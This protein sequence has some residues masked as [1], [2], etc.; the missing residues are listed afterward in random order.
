MPI[1]HLNFKTHLHPYKR[2]LLCLLLLKTVLLTLFILYG[3]IGLGPDEA[4]Y[5]TWSRTL[6][7]GYYSKPP[8]I[9]WQIWLGTQIFGQ[10][11]FGVRALSILLSYAQTF[12]VFFLAI[13]SGLEKR[14]AFWCGVIMAFSPIGIVGSFLA[15][16]DTGFLLFWTLAS[17]VVVS[18]LKEKKEASPYPI[19]ILIALGALFKWPVYIF[20]FFFFI[21]RKWYFP[22]LSLGKSMVGV[23]LSLAGLL[24][25]IV[26]NISHDWATFRHVFSTMQGGNAPALK[27]NLLEF[28][29]SQALLLSPVLFILL[30]LAF[31]QT[32]QKGVKLNPQLT[33]CTVVSAGSLT[34]LLIASYIQK[35]QG[36]WGVFIYPTG[37][38]LIGWYACEWQ[39]KKMAWLRWGV[40]LSIILTGLVFSLSSFTS[41]KKFYKI[42]PFKHNTGWRE[43][44]DALDEAGYLPERHFLAGDKYQTA[45]ILSFYNTGQKRAYFLN[46]QGIR[47]N[48]F[49][50][51][52][53]LR[54]EQKNQ[55]GYFV[56]VVDSSD[57][58][59]EVELKLPLYLKVLKESFG[60][61]EFLRFIPLLVH[62]D[63]VTKGICLFRCSNI[64]NSQIPDSRLY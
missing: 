44:R 12:A 28:F 8:G 38:I 49:S 57:L 15:I 7:W 39:Q 25:S 58:N 63:E 61:V 23:L 35:I 51:W 41:H 59:N 46:L 48:Q 14:T 62:G 34:L 64:N 37:I 19:G 21:A 26:W 43:L 40:G 2:L 22:S 53:Q 60:D 33:F 47:N 1:E 45:S 10:T 42:N 55:T 5:W 9:A 52:P 6:D 54:E 13:R 36:N 56:W 50:Y 17:L 18:A 24:P 20:W 31:Y 30:L 3:P 29:G 27:G 11:E 32:A 16:T 4:Q